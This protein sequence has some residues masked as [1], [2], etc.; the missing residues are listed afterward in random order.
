MNPLHQ[1]PKHYLCEN[2]GDIADEY[3]DDQWLCLDCVNEEDED[4]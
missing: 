2:C 1:N 4:L 3:Y